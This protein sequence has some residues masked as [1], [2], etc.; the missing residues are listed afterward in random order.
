MKM[1]FS[2]VIGKADWS[3]EKVVSDCSGSL[4]EAT[5]G[6]CNTFCPSRGWLE[7]ASGALCGCP[8]QHVGWVELV[9]EMDEPMV[10]WG[11][12]HAVCWR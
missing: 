5:G 1:G 10:D 12:Q 7:D 3:M 8:F 11:L 6:A 9:Q 4:R 2:V